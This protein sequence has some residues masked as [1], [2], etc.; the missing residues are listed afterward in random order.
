MNPRDPIDRLLEEHRE[1]MAQVEL[2]RGAVA[3]LAKRGEPALP[4]ALP[5]FE[6]AGRMMATLLL[7]HA[8]R[9][10][11]ALF[12]ALESAFGG[13][14]GPTMMMRQEHRMIHAQAE[15]FHRTLH[16]LEAVEH[17]AIVAGGAA[18]RELTGRGGSAEGLR[19]TGAEIIRLL[20]LHFGKEEDILFPMARQA[21]SPEEL[22]EIALKM[23]TIEGS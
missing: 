3:S 22:E 4:D 1:I 2:L 17:P 16:E 23:E 5:A 13:G 15:L 11:E 6:S 10:G 7:S 19:D 8:R 12:P 21:L 9:E 14:G 20:D 18:L